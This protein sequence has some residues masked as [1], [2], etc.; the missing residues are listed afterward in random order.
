MYEYS[1]P[2]TEPHFDITVFYSSGRI[3]ISTGNY[4]V[5]HDI[6]KGGEVHRPCHIHQLY[7]EKPYLEQTVVD[8]NE[9]SLHFMKE[10]IFCKKTTQECN[11][12]VKILQRK[13]RENQENMSMIN[14]EELSWEF[15]AR[16]KQMEVIQM[17][18]G[19]SARHVSS[20]IQMGRHPPPVV[21]I[22]LKGLCILRGVKPSYDSNNQETY[23]KKIKKL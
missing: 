10:M 12:K 22:L 23:V 19:L 8:C 1:T 18:R 7:N 4:D 5:I 11:T 3:A 21:Q 2:N 9:K 15:A 20:V 16:E 13:L 14:E 6:V 17:L